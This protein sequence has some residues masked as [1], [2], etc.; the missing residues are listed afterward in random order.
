ME[1]CTPREYML[2]AFPIAA[3]EAEPEEI[4]RTAYRKRNFFDKLLR[5]PKRR[6]RYYITEPSYTYW[7]GFASLAAPIYLEGYWQQEQYF[8]DIADVIRQD[9]AFPLLPSASALLADRIA[10]SPDSISI[11]IRRGDYLSNP[12]AN[13]VLGPCSIEYYREAMAR[14]LSATGG[15]GHAFF[16]SDDPGWIREHLDIQGIPTILIG[17][18]GHA[19]APWHDMHLMRLC[20]HHIIANSS[21]SWWGA[22]LSSGEGLI[23]APQRWFAEKTMRHDNPA[24]ASWVKI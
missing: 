23:V 3:A 2:H 16:F 8:S 13:T 1:G 7:P 20:K 18:A 24:A 9:F 17:C 11:H 10:Q 14:V 6:S 19:A 22:W 4:E 21:F 5:R 15:Q 12:I